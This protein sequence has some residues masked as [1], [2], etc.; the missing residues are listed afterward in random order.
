MIRVAEDYYKG[1]YRDKSLMSWQH[2]QKQPA[3]NDMK[4]EAIL[5]A[6]AMSASAKP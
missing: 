2:V 6:P 1:C 5:L 3:A 4:G